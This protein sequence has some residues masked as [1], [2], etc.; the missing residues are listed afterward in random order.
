MTDPSNSPT[1]NICGGEHDAM[2]CPKLGDYLA[3]ASQWLAEDGLRSYAA[4]IDIARRRISAAEA[5]VA[6]LPKTA[7]GV[8]MILGERYWIP[9]SIGQVFEQQQLIEIGLEEVVF[10]V[11]SHLDVIRFPR[12]CYSTRAAAEAAKEKG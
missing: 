6:K 4:A 10:G 2:V 11:L 5:I 9:S 12:E 3:E 8:T 7:D 1:C